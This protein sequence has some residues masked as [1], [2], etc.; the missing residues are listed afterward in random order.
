MKVVNEVAGSSLYSSSPLWQEERIHCLYAIYLNYIEF[1]THTSTGSSPH[2][3]CSPFPP[4]PVL[5]YNVCFPRV[6][7][8]VYEL[9][10]SDYAPSALGHPPAHQNFKVYIVALP[11]FSHGPPP[12]WSLHHLPL[13]RLFLKW[14]PE[15]GR[16]AGRCLPHPGAGLR[17]DPPPGSSEGSH[18]PH[19]SL[20]RLTAFGLV[21]LLLPF[22]GLFLGCG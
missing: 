7:H 3:Y 17:P 20:Q 6:L 15:R 1:H 18:R 14:P 8:L 13:S 2:H 10:L 12:R 4:S 16:T 9:T 22:L 19:D 5:V 21:E 11:G